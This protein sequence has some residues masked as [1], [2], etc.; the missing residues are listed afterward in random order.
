[1]TRILLVDDHAVVRDGIKRMFDEKSGAVSFGEAD[2]PESAMKLVEGQEW[3]VVSGYHTRGSGGLEVLKE[4]RKSAS[5]SCVD[6]QYAFRRAV[7]A[8]FRAGTSGYVTRTAARRTRRAVR[9]FPAGASTSLQLAEKLVLDLERGTDRPPH[10]H[11][12]DREYEVLRFIAS[13]KTVGE[14]AN[15]FS[16]RQNH[17]HIPCADSRRWG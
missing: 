11:L 6:P 4:L 15:S 7:C 16:Q 3:D 10:E 17:Q 12:S 1:M 5:P 14:I 8:A 13:G 2:S 9:R